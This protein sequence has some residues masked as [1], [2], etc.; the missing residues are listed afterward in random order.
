[1]F[2]N[3]SCLKALL[4]FQLS[5]R[6]RSSTEQS[7]KQALLLHDKATS[8]CIHSC[9]TAKQRNQLSWPWFFAAQKPASPKPHFP[10]SE[11]D[12]FGRPPYLSSISSLPSGASKQ[13]HMAEI[14]IRQETR[15][16]II[17]SSGSSA[18]PDCAVPCPELQQA[19]TS[20]QPEAETQLTFEECFCSS[21]TIESLFFSGDSV[22]TT[23]CTVASDRNL[24]S[25]WAFHFCGKVIQG[26]DPLTMIQLA[27]SITTVTVTST[28]AVTEGTLSSSASPLSSSKDYPKSSLISSITQPSTTSGEATSMPSQG[29]SSRTTT[30]TTSTYLGLPSPQLPSA[31]PTSHT[32]VN[33]G[34]VAGS[35]VGGSLFLIFVFALICCVSRQIMLSRKSKQEVA[36]SSPPVEFPQQSGSSPRWEE[37]PE[38]PAN[39]EK[40][41]DVQRFA[42]DSKLESQNL[43]PSAW[44][45]WSG[46]AELP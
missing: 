28:S 3:P 42:M 5:S 11:I 13:F 44:Q 25:D 30:P 16:L 8:D 34:I 46:R 10:L 20:C 7:V 31:S 33:I 39:L 19:Q 22:C 2:D 6:S 1:M 29:D 36:P 40:D 14:E 26:I 37:P 32:T 18:F 21:D 45:G 43:A 4:S 23:Q 15:T 12:H 9:R 35:A 27:P 38:K 17:P 24:L 41:D